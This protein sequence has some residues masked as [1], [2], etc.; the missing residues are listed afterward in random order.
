MEDNQG[1][2]QKN[3]QQILEENQANNTNAN[4]T[5][6]SNNDQTDILG[7]LSIVFAFIFAPV[8]LVLGIIGRKEALKEGRSTT[9]SKVGIWINAILMAIGVLGFILFILFFGFLAAS[10]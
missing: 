7:I 8:G 6:S 10:A 5:S 9:L 4:N 1:N 2:E 3:T